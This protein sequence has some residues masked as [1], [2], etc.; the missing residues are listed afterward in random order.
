MV[1]SGSVVMSVVIPVVGSVSLADTVVDTVV[2]VVGFVGSVDAVVSAVPLPSDP[3]SLG[4][5]V[6]DT[7]QGATRARRRMA[8]PPRVQLAGRS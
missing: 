2:D 7:I 1:V 6:R 8:K 4:Q 5:P 3:L